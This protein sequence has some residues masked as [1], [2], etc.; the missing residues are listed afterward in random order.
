MKLGPASPSSSDPQQPAPVKP[1]PVKPVPVQ[2]A[3]PVQ[4]VPV[5]PVPV[6]PVPVQ[7]VPVAPVPVQPVPVAPVSPLQPVGND[8]LFGNDPLGNAGASNDPLGDF[9]TGYSAPAPVHQQQHYDRP[10]RNNRR[11]KSSSKHSPTGP[12]LSIIGGL[13]ALILGIVL[14]IYGINA[15]VT[16]IDAL[17]TASDLG[18]KM[19]AS[20]I[21]RFLLLIVYVLSIIA[22][23]GAG[24]YSLILGIIE[25]VQD[26][27]KSIASKVALGACSAYALVM[28]IMMIV[29]I[30]D[31]NSAK[32]TLG[33]GFGLVARNAGRFGGLYGVKVPTIGGTIVSLFLLLIIPAFV[34]FVGIFRWNDDS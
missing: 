34:I 9:G 30:V 29:R 24:G 1:A 32:K 7:P 22:M 14:A 2:P 20:V 28:V 27:R 31:I 3:P 33:A 15:L 16:A 13:A 11:R 19:P 17:S 26:Y 25:L 4:A 18:V 6:Q 21:V 5:Q 10:R 12:I 8:S 23:A